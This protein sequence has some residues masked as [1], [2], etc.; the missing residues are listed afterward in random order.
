MGLMAVMI[1]TLELSVNL[2]AMP[3]SLSLSLLPMTAITA[4]TMV[5][6]L[7]LMSSQTASVS[8]SST[9]VCRPVSS[10]C[11]IGLLKY[12]DLAFPRM[13]HWEIF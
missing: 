9:S 7:L 13:H 10:V 1:G 2:S 12:F 6:G 8:F 4:E 3:A 5:F 11:R